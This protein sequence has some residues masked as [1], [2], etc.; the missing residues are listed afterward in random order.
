MK[1][2]KT[3]TKHNILHSIRR[4]RDNVVLKTIQQSALKQT[5]QFGK[6]FQHKY[7]HKQQKE[8]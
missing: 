6:H 7:T 4:E 8:Q 1:C 3:S 2:Y 5:V